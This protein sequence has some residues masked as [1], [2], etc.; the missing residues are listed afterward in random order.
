MLEEDSTFDTQLHQRRPNPACCKTSRRKTQATE[1]KA[2]AMST[3][4]KT[5]D[6]RRLYISWQAHLTS[7]KLS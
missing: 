5:Q 1:S 7:W 6:C 3:L 4:S 2:F